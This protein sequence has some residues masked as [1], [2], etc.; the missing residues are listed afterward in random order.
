MNMGHVK[1]RVATARKGTALLYAH[2]V[3]PSTQPIKSGGVLKATLAIQR[4][5]SQHNPRL[6]QSNM[7]PPPK[8]LRW[9]WMVRVAFNMPPLSIGQ[10][11][12]TTGQV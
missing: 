11:N 3:V 2:P 5:D 6:T 7:L 8:S 12:S 4:S 9:I 10:V 1:E